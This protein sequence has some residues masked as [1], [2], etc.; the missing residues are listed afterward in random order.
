VAS[1]YNLY[2]NLTAR[3]WI[4]YGDVYI[5]AMKKELTTG[6]ITQAQVDA[7]WKKRASLL[8]GGKDS[9]G[10][11]PAPPTPALPLPSSVTMP[12]GSPAVNQAWSKAETAVSSAVQSA[13]GSLGVSSKYFGLG[14]AGI[15]FILI[16]TR[17]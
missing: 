10:N 6:E 4:D 13:A 7:V 14:L 3:Q 2:M 5:T 12:I 8:Q 15:V 16:L 1:N 17:R 11:T 9:H